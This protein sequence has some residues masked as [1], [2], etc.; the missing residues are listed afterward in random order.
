MESNYKEPKIK[1]LIIDDNVDE[2]RMILNFLAEDPDIEICT[3][4]SSGFDIVSGIKFHKPDVVVT[5]FLATDADETIVLEKINS[6]DMKNRPR[7]IVMSSLDNAK[8]SEKAFSYGIDYYIRKPI[9]LSLLK[10]AIIL[11]TKG[12]KPYKTNES[13]R[14]AKIRGVVRSVGIPVNIL[15]YTYIVETIKYMMDSEKAVFLSEVYKSISKNHNT[16]VECIEVSIRNAI[17][18][19]T[20]T[21]NE[22]FKRIFQ[23]C[24]MK[25][26]NSVF[27]SNLKETIFVDLYK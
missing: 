25:P 8:V 15:G 21:H 7:I 23:S 14:M 4:L 2:R 24:N 22:N 6:S 19:A 5:D 26:S 20:H 11:V 13:V 18:K 27:L 9:I 10:D 16:S 3:F 12:R 17:K 1:V